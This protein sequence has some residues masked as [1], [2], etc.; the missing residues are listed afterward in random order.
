MTKQERYILA[1]I[2]GTPIAIIVLNKIYHT[3]YQLLFPCVSDS[4]YCNSPMLPGFLTMFTSLALIS[5]AVY[6][7]VKNKL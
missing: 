5:F 7:V 3:I 4:Y 6:L 1:A 2:V